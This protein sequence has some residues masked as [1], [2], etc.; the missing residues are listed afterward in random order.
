MQKNSKNKDIIIIGFAL[1]AMF[2][3]SGNLI[4]PPYLGRMVGGEYFSALVG[5]MIM[6]VGLPLLGV[7]ATAKAGGDFEIIGNRVD[8]TFSI[9]LV[10]ALVLAIGPFL[11]IPRTAATTYEI[12]VRPFLPGVSP[13]VMIAI[14]FAINLFFVISPN[15]IVDV[16][17]KFLTP[18]LLVTLAI[19]IVKGIAFPIGPVTETTLENVFSNSLIEGYQTMD[20]LAAV[21]FGGI[22]VNNIKS[23]GYKKSSQI[24]SMTLKA[25]LVAIAGLGLVYG[26]LMYLGTHTG[27]IVGA[28]EKTALVSTLAYQ[29][30]GQAGTV[31]L[32]IAVALA[33]LTTS[34]G[35]TATGA[36]YF[37]KLFKDRISYK[38]VA[39]II[40]LISNLDNSNH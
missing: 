34:I 6:G 29:I 14:Y 19:L 2:F 38:A 13:I 26:G 31:F 37:S 22:I 33:C 39:I 27:H 5:F 4:F 20:A 15:S 1:F 11:A 12:S 28:V 7:M 8:R 35:L 17:G 30:L 40:S 36:T 9:V 23:K 32:A 21:C 16:I 3:G 24:I 10:T 18:T 25:S